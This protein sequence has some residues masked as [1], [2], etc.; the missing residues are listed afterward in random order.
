M[1]WKNI[2][3]KGDAWEMKEMYGT[4]TPQDLPLWGMSAEEKEEYYKSDEFLDVEVR[5]YMLDEND[6]RVE[7]QSDIWEAPATEKRYVYEVFPEVYLEYGELIDDA[8]KKGL[9]IKGAGFDIHKDAYW[10]Q[11]GPEWSRVEL[12]DNDKELI[13]SHYETIEELKNKGFGG[14]E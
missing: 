1:S 8:N 7:E 4:S 12:D 10:E 9:N 5:Y 3:R 13:D 6:N 14:G 11:D 2:L